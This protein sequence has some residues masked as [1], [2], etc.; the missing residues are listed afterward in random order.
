MRRSSFATPANGT[1]RPEAAGRG[2]PLADGSVR[3]T[4]RPGAAAYQLVAISSLDELQS[5]GFDGWR[6]LMWHLPIRAAHDVR[7]QHAGT[8]HSSPFVSSMLAPSRGHRSA[9][10]NAGGKCQTLATWASIGIGTAAIDWSKGWLSRSTQR[11]ALPA[12]RSATGSRAPSA[13]DR[14]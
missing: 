6:H 2:R 12:R 14:Q 9:S 1:E 7:P 3:P 4:R 11:R 8:R 5:V 13:R 10:A